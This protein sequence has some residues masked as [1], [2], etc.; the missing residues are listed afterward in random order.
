M[1]HRLLK[2]SIGTAVLVTTLSRTAFADEKKPVTTVLARESLGVAVTDDGAAFVNDLLIGPR[3]Y[4]DLEAMVTVAVE[5]G[6]SAVLETR[7]PGYHAFSAGFALGVGVSN[8]LVHFTIQPRLLVGTIAEELTVGFRTSLTTH[9]AWEVLS[10]ELG[11]EYFDSD[12]RDIQEK[13]FV[14][15]IG[16]DVGALTTAVIGILVWSGIGRSLR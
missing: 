8:R 14:G 10:L 4:F 1:S 5:L 13:A 12:H 15:L 2:R 9:F 7:Y 11:Y 6:Y 3:V 16:L